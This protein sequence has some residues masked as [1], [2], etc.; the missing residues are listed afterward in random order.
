MKTLKTVI[1]N[2]MRKDKNL[3]HKLI[4]ERLG[5]TEQAYYQQLKRDTTKMNTRE[6]FARVLNINI[7]C[8]NEN[9]NEK[10]DFWEQKSIEWNQKEDNYRRTIENLLSTISNL[11]LGKRRGVLSV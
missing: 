4:V 1:E 5:M 10:T 8:F 9:V 11:S 6:R 3:T 2:E 7:E